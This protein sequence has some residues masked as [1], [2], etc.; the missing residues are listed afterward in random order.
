MDVSNFFNPGLYKITCL[1]NQKIYIGE[2]E[3]V[4]SRLGRHV[5]SLEKKRHDCVELQTDFNLYGK[6][7]FK[8][9]EHRC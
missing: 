9:S 1:T 8:F 6:K 2:S 4:L 7:Y 3:N 5:E